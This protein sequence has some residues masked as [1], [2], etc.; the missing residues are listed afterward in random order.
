MC[1][2]VWIKFQVA[3]PVRAFFPPGPT[4]VCLQGHWSFSSPN[5]FQI[6]VLSNIIYFRTFIISACNGYSVVEQVYLRM[7]KLRVCLVCFLII[8]NPVLHHCWMWMTWMRL[9][10]LKKVSKYERRTYARNKT[11][12]FVDCTMR[13]FDIIHTYVD[14]KS[15]A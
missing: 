15:M 1:L 3:K 5:E 13:F 6:G 11:Y 7:F 12:V 8:P 14:I 9:T 4:N 10:T 2:R